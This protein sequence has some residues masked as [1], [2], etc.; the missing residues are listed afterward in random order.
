[1]PPL[2]VR[3]MVVVLWGR[4]KRKRSKRRRKDIVREGPGQ[5]RVEDYKGEAS[6]AKKKEEQ[7]RAR[8]G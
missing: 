8:N 4:G 6:K 1:M 3:R 7:S 5:R 2:T